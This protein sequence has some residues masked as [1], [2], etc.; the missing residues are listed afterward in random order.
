MEREKE[1]R[2]EKYIILC[3]MHFKRGNTKERKKDTKERKKRREKMK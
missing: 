1:R 2:N 3:K